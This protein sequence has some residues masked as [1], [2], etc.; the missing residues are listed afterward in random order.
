MITQTAWKKL[1]DERSSTEDNDFFSLLE[2][3]T[4]N[5][6]YFI[7]DKSNSLFTN[8]Y[9]SQNEFDVLICGGFDRKMRKYLKGVYR[10]DGKSLKNVKTVPPMLKESSNFKTVYLKRQV[11]AI[12]HRFK[13]SSI[14]KYSPSLDAWSKVTHMYDFRYDFCACAFMREILIIGGC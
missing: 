2:E 4:V 8:R 13:N 11:Y 5:N 14:D 3:A 9:C 7:Q 6:K 1:T 12:Q 10:I